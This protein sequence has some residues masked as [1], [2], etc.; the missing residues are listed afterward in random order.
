MTNRIALAFVP[1]FL[2]ILAPV[3]L[4]FAA[5]SSQGITGALGLGGFSLAAMLVLLNAFMRAEAMHTRQRVAETA[6]QAL[7]AIF[8]FAQN[9]RDRQAEAEQAAEFVEALRQLD[10]AAAEDEAQPGQVVDMV[11]DLRMV[12]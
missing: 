7:P 12:A 3:A 1:L 2:L 9:M 6:L 10:A 8:A 5:D 11:G 4:Y